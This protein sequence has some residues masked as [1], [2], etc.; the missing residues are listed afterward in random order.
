[1]G[2][3]IA[4]EF[5]VAGYNVVLVAR[6]EQKFQAALRMMRANLSMLADI[7]GFPRDH[8]QFALNKIVPAF[9]I[10]EGA[11]NADLVIEAVSE[12]VLLKQDVFQELDAASPDRTIL[13][14]TTS[15]IMP[16]KVASVTN[17]PDRVIGAHFL[18]PPFVVPLVEVIMTPDTSD[19]T[20]NVVVSV[21]ETVGKKPVVLRK[22]MPGFVINRLQ[23][24]LL[25]EAFW[26]V[27]QNAA[28]PADVDFAIRHSIGP[29]WT[30]AGVFGAFELAGWDVIL[31]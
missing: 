29:R 18:N 13:G 7:R 3:G 17:R 12:D 21:L 19:E 22:E 15:A 14:T 30:A 8:L 31:A 2:H 23:A 28:S 16:S 25:R 4:Q 5:A 24:A 20:L 9:S 10:K 11:A 6:S 27:G 26:I 1:M